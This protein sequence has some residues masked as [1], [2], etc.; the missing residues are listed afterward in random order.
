MFIY[1]TFYLLYTNLLLV[2]FS[3]CTKGGY[4]VTSFSGQST[5]YILGDDFRSSISVLKNN[6]DEEEF[7]PDPSTDTLVLLRTKEYHQRKRSSSKRDDLVEVKLKLPRPNENSTDAQL[8]V[9]IFNDDTE[10]PMT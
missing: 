7:Q 10:Y 8:L 9:T 6:G 5:C 4:F 3:M 1:V 2:F